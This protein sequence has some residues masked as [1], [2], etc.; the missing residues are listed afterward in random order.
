VFGR[1]T[2]TIVDDRLVRYLQRA[3]LFLKCLR[4]PG[5]RFWSAPARALLKPRFSS[6]KSPAGLDLRPVQE[7]AGKS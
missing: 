5:G 2:P 4:L 6:V 3:D 7:A 1:T